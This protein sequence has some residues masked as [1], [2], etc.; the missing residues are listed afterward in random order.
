V[1]PR[2]F[3][4]MR[5]LH[6]LFPCAAHAA[7]LGGVALQ[8]LDAIERS[9][10][11][12][13]RFEP[14]YWLLSAGRGL[15]RPYQRRLLPHLL[16][17]AARRV[18]AEK[19]FTPW[20]TRRF[21]QDVRPGDVAWLFPGTDAATFAHARDR[22]AYV[23]K[24]LVNTAF[25]AHRDAL[26]RAHAALGWPAQDLPRDADVAEER[27]QLEHADLLFTCS[28]F[29][30]RSYVAAGARE[31]TLANVSY[32]WSARE[33]R[34]QRTRNDL[35]RLLFVARGSV[36][37]GLPHLL[38][39]WRRARPPATLVIV[40]DLDPIVAERCADDLRQPGVEY[41]AWTDDL[42]ACYGRADA[43]VLPSFEEGSP[44]VT[45]LALAAGLPCLLSPEAAGWLVRDG[46][47][48]LIAEAH[49]TDA[50]SE[51]LHRAAGDRELRERLGARALERSRDY[52]WDP[53]AARRCEAIERRLGA[54]M[55]G[56]A[57]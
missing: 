3:S 11:L 48:G 43:F 6:L 5:R 14:H 22:G 41:N 7:G 55:A 52:D 45:Y 20:L 49:D 30:S 37:K 54:A 4:P 38:R 1:P 44:L 51:L 35:P 25:A 36:R 50:W 33:F 9:P 24:E 2:A 19:A 29:V 40:G 12:R 10:S 46:E 39:A 57:R 32:G 23:V 18:V 8:M 21:L 15:E 26:V 31:S 13:A 17:R 42:A 34:P 53:V 16:A 27:A 28:P 47:E 56:A